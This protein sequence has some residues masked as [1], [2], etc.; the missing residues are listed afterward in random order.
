VANFLIGFMRQLDIQIT[1]K[2]RDKK[3]VNSLSYLK[4]T[5]GYVL[6]AYF[7]ILFLKHSDIDMYVSVN[8]HDFH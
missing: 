5:F 1:K 4:F 8:E 6:L 7:M 3:I 2:F